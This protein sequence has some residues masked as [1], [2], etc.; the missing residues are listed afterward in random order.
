L[1]VIE[2]GLGRH[3]IA[4]CQRNLRRRRPGPRLN[5]T[6]P[7]APRNS[8]RCLGLAR[9]AVEIAEREVRPSEGIVLDTA[10]HVDIRLF[11]EIDRF[12]GGK[13]R[14]LRT[15]GLDVRSGK[16]LERVDELSDE[17]L[18]AACPNRGF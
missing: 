13:Q 17:P 16:V 8:Q 6:L 10:D 3:E 9:G 15:A 5:T 11:L 12:L 2:Q 7:S 4:A 1:C 14:V 18:V